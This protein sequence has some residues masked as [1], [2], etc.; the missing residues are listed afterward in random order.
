M[1]WR[2]T[3]RRKQSIYFNKSNSAFQ[4]ELNIFLLYINHRL[5][6]WCYEC[7]T[8]IENIDGILKQTVDLIKSEL[9]KPKHATPP[10]VHENGLSPSA[11]QPDENSVDTKPPPANAQVNAEAMRSLLGNTLNIIHSLSSNSVGLADGQGFI[12]ETLKNLPRVRGLSNL[13]NTCFFNA[14]MQCLAQTPYLL[15]T[16]NEL[17]EPKETEW[18]KWFCTDFSRSPVN[19]RKYSKISFFCDVDF[20]CLAANLRPR[21]KARRKSSILS[22]FLV[23]WNHG[24]HSPPHW[25]KLWKNY[26]DRAVSSIPANCFRL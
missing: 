5:E 3:L 22:R 23:N 18:V 17:A 19:M 7:D 2:S 16:L 11:V 15:E 1:R 9:A 26:R 12:A 8:S 24:D 21:L 14:V 13:G 6:V 25:L 20:T 10:K 4:L